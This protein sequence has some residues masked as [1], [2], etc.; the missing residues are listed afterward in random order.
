MVRI[1]SCRLGI[2]F[3]LIWVFV[4][5]CFCRSPAPKSKKRSSGPNIADFYGRGGESDVED[6]ETVYSK[7]TNKG[8]LQSQAAEAGTHT[9]DGQLR[10]QVCEG[11]FRYCHLF[12]VAVP[13]DRR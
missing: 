4:L 9:E 7:D 10:P 3:T 8:M 1:G 6:E 13:E 5:T 12:V 11:T 2:A